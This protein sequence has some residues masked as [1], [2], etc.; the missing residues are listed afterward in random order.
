MESSLI[1]HPSSLIPHPA[2]GH[3][4]KLP[5]SLKKRGVIG[6]V[7]PYLFHVGKYSYGFMAIRIY[8]ASAQE[9]PGL[10]RPSPIAEE[11]ALRFLR[12]RPEEVDRKHI[13][14]LMRCALKQAAG[15]EKGNSLLRLRLPSHPDEKQLSPGKAP[16]FYPGPVTLSGH[17][18]LPV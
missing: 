9:W 5:F 14:A 6:N 13:D 4:K 17:L 16:A 1:P 2:R 15:E 3:R 10:M 8:N 11:Q 18:I 12:R 7:P